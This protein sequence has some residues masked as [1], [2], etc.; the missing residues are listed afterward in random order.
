M[1]DN[2]ENTIQTSLRLPTW[3]YVEIKNQAA[4]SD[5]T[6]SDQIRFMLKRYIE[7]SKK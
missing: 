7:F 2:H 1:S 6:I 3:L 4:D 5:R